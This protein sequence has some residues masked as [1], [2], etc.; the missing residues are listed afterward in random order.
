MDSYLEALEKLGRLLDAGVLTKE[1]FEAEKRHLLNSRRVDHQVDARP[2]RPRWQNPLVIIAVIAGILAASVLGFF[3]VRD[4]SNA[5]SETNAVQPSASKKGLSTDLSVT[6]ADAGN[7]EPGPSL[8]NLLSRIREGGRADE[9]SDLRLIS[10]T[11]DP[12]PVEVQSAVRSFGQQQVT[13]ARLPVQSE[14]QGLHIT[15][16]GTMEWDQGTG[17][18]LRFEE[19]PEV[20]ARTLQQAGFKVKEAG[21]PIE[22]LGTFAAIE[23]TSG[24]ATLTC[25]K[26]NISALSSEGE[27]ESNSTG[28]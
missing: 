16:V 4:I 17:F 27:D 19:A 14:W 6:F 5:K 10:L 24:G 7:C 25:M 9:G 26:S 11:G 15:E 21:K 28:E 20:A 1:E 12:N 3:L 22:N 23:N 2:S 13:L 18:Q 8:S